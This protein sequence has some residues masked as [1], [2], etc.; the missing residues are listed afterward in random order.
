MLRTASCFVGKSFLIKAAACDRPQY[1]RVENERV[2]GTTQKKEGHS[3]ALQ[4]RK[5]PNTAHEH[6]SS[7]KKTLDD[8]YCGF[9]LYSKARGGQKR[10]LTRPGNQIEGPVTLSQSQEVKFFLA[11]T[12]REPETIQE[13]QQREGLL[14]VHRRE[15]TLRSNSDSYLV[16]ERPSDESPFILTEKKELDP[17]NANA[18]CQFSLDHSTE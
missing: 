9:S 3:F 17:N 11:G 5:R 10:F 4:I 12:D 14:I 2:Q 18:L 7:A 8:P 15:R 6:D 13:W 1:L 16:L